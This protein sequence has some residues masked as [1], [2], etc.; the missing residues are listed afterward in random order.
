[1]ALPIMLTIGGI[2]LVIMIAVVSTYIEVGRHVIVGVL[3][4]VESTRGLGD[5][6]LYSCNKVLHPIAHPK[7]VYSRLD[8]H[9][10]TVRCYAGRSGVEWETVGVCT[11]TFSGEDN[12]LACASTRQSI[13]WVEG[14][15][16]SNIVVGS[17][18]YLG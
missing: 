1:M 7:L 3:D 5:G 17:Y 11:A 15:G 18:L 9:V 8:D 6:S 12:L 4:I 2:P 13:C 14:I 10:S 16:S